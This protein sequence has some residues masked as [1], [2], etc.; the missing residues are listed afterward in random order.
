MLDPGPIG[1][2]ST[3]LATVVHHRIH[4]PDRGGVVVDGVQVVQHSRLER[5][6]D[7]AAPDAQGPDSANRPGEVR[8]AEGLVNEVQ[9]QSR[10]PGV[11]QRHAQGAGPRGDRDANG[12]GAVDHS[13]PCRAGIVRIAP[14]AEQYRSLSNG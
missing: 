6:G 13:A 11:V 9:A 2:E 14:T 5:H 10:I 7:S 12:R 3:D 8:G 4:G 1:I